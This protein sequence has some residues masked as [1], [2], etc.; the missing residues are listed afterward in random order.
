MIGA[1]IKEWLSELGVGCSPRRGE[2]RRYFL[3]RG[4]PSTIFL[5]PVVARPAGLIKEGQRWPHVRMPDQGFL[6]IWR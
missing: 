6:H 5:S 3:T 2:H 4:P 1:T